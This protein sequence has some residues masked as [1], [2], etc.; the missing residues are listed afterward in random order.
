LN[1]VHALSR[2]SGNLHIPHDFRGCEVHHQF[3]SRGHVVVRAC[4]SKEQRGEELIAAGLLMLAGHTD[5]DE[6][7]SWLRVGWER[8][9]GASV[10][11][12]DSHD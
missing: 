9:R 4:S 8:R 2:F 11:Y 5:L 3:D 1:E 7:D 12:P 10:P 6:L